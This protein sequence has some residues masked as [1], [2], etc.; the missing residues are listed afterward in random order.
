MTGGTLPAM[1]WH[2]IMAY[3][4]QGVELRQLPGM[5]APQHAPAVADASF[6]GSDEPHPIL[7]TRKGTDALVRVERLLDEAEHA[8]SVQATPAGT[9][10]ALDSAK[11]RAGTVTAATDQQSPG[12]SRGD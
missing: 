9:L 6:K 11:D 10:G 1:T 7:L 2:N 5:P 3:A 12:T 8:L 4:H